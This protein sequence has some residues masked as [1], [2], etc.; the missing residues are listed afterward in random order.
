[1]ANSSCFHQVC[2]W[3]EKRPSLDLGIHLNFTWGIPLCDPKDISSLVDGAGKFHSSPALYARALLGRIK[4]EHV[5][6]EGKAQMEKVFARKLNITHID[7]HHHAHVLPGL[8]EAVADLALEYRVSFVRSLTSQ[9]HWVADGPLSRRI[10]LGQMPGAHRQFWTKKGLFTVGCL[11]GCD[12]GGN[13]KNLL[14]CWDKFLTLLPEG[15]TEV[16][17]HP[18]YVDDLIGDSYREGRLKEIDLLCDPR[19]K[20]MI[21]KADISLI[22]FSHLLK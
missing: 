3:L 5:Y 9:K 20:K 19:F 21:K 13:Q 11:K 17:V 6:K 16:M 8:C 4:K 2:E 14:V 18:G 1:M 12:L 7:S 10:F 22:G 15:V